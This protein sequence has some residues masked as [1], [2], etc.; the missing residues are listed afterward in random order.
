M[1]RF[2]YGVFF[3]PLAKKRTGK[4]TTEQTAHLRKKRK[5]KNNARTYFMGP[6]FCLDAGLRGFVIIALP[7]Q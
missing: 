4:N 5:E 7:T 3:S 2:V 6:G 1:S